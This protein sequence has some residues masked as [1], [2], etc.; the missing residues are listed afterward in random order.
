MTLTL[1]GLDFITVVKILVNNSPE[2][3]EEDRIECNRGLF[4]GSAD[5]MNAIVWIITRSCSALGAPVCCYCLFRMSPKN[6]NQPSRKKAG[7]A[8]SADTLDAS[9]TMLPD[10]V[11]D[12]LSQS[13]MSMSYSR[14]GEQSF[15]REGKSLLK[16]IKKY[17]D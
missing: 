3:K 2:T 5:F 14:A 9:Q 16:K 7:L 1:F 8:N 6:L 17:D 4:S 12:N 13:D 10:D 11:S 15:Y